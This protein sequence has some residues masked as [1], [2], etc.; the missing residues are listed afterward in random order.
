MRHQS[1]IYSG[2]PRLSIQWP[3][4]TQTSQVLFETSYRLS[5]FSS[6]RW[7]YIY[8]YNV[9]ALASIW[10]LHRFAIHMELAW[11]IATVQKNPICLKLNTRRTLYGKSKW[12]AHFQCH[13]IH[14]MDIRIKEWTHG[15]TICI[16]G[17]KELSQKSDKRITDC[18]NLINQVSELNI[19]SIA[20]EKLDPEFFA[21]VLTFPRV[22]QGWF[23]AW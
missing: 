4:Q 20:I 8:R 2:T 9:S 13:L 1:K 5:S 15:T 19:N 23:Y 6:I 10:K 3:Q 17:S 18:P 11:M 12:H 14:L 16:I 21:K 7:I 22:F